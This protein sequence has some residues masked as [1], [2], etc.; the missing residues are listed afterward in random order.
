[1]NTQAPSLSTV[2]L[3]A[4][5]TA[6]GK[7]AL[8]LALAER[9]GG[10]V[11]NAD[12]AQVYRDLAIV[13]ARPGAAATAR[14][15]HRLYGTRDGADSCSAADWAA[16]ARAEIAAAHEAGRLP[17]LAGGTGLY[18]RTLIEGIA[19]VPEIDRAVR[20]AVRALGAGEAHAALAREDPAA[21]TRIRPGDTSRAQRALEVVRA[22]GRTLKDWQAE[23]VGGIA[24]AVALRPLILL[25]PRDWLHARCDE[26]LEKIFS[27]EGIEEVRSLLER[28]LPAFAPVM[29]AIGVREIAALLRGEM[30]REQALAAGKI[31]TRQYA[32]RQYTWF[33]RQPPADWPRFEAALDC[34]RVADA[35]ALIGF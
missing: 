19:P 4:G 20:A 22:T 9:V 25:P 13:S 3:I 16:D 34:D 8:A 6:S 21:A 15:P 23:K 7:S 33:R 10:V 35:L 12:S 24:G 31:A 30:S 29:R 14:A 26:R 18:I 28:N 5:P 27:D 11:I 32:K 17:I 1:M 2:A